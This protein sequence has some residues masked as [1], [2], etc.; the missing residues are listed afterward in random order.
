PVTEDPLVYQHRDGLGNIGSIDDR[1]EY[2]LSRPLWDHT[3]VSDL[4][5]CG[6]VRMDP[7]SVFRIRL[8]P[9]GNRE[10][11]LVIDCQESI[12]MLRWNQ[13]TVRQTHFPKGYFSTERELTFGYFDERVVARLGTE[14]EMQSLDLPEDA[15]GFGAANSTPLTMAAYGGNVT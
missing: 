14:C 13:E 11:N 9:V 15:E 12:A 7:S 2:T 5:I 6:T 4:L 3:P 10:F 8:H 1:T